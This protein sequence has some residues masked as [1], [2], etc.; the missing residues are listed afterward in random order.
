[1]VKLKVLETNQN[2]I[3]WLG[4]RK[5]NFNEDTNEFFTSFFPYYDL[6]ITLSFVIASISFSVI[7]WPQMD[8]VCE[9]CIVVLS[10][11]QVSG[12]FFSFGMKIKKI[13]AVHIQLQEI[14]NG[15]GRYEFFFVRILI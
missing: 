8:I 11:S 5:F 15:E 14:I 3:N 13:K 2:F 12:M 10:G 1:M 9:S 4:V 6:F 7:H